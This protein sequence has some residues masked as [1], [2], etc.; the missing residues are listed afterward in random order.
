VSIGQV[1]SFHKFFKVI[2]S[3]E[4]FLDQQSHKKL[5]VTEYDKLIGLET[6]RRIAV[7]TE[8]ERS[9]DESM[10]LLVDLHLK[11]D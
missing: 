5:H 1:K 6:L 3:H 2:N 4:G 7:E 10:D 8:N 9:R 11:F